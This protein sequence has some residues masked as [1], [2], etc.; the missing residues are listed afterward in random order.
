MKLKLSPYRLAAAGALA[1]VVFLGLGLAAPAGTCTPQDTGPA[2]CTDPAAPWTYTGDV[3][4]A[5]AALTVIVTA[6]VRRLRRKGA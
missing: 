5:L 3:L 6:V 4:L 1:G 2:V